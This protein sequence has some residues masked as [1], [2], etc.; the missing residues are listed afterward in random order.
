[1]QA[2]KKLENL[3]IIYHYIFVILVVWGFLFFRDRVVREQTGG[4]WDKVGK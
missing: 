1:M 3:H 2:Y 4:E